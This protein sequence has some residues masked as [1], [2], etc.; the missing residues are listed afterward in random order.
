MIIT[1]E[2][3]YI[4]KH[5]L[6]IFLTEIKDGNNKENKQLPIEKVK[7][8]LENND[9]TSL[10]KSMEKQIIKD[11]VDETNGNIAEAARRLGVSRQNL[12]YRIKKYKI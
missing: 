3:E 12:E 6:P 11:K 4:Q 10:M 1:N 5:D 2:K 9:L 8:E 7:A